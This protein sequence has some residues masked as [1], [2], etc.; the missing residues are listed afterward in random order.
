MKIQQA[1]SAAYEASKCITRATFPWNRGFLKLKLGDNE[2]NYLFD[3]YNANGNKCG[4]GSKPQLSDI[5]ANDWEV[6]D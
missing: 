6:C 2:E 4:H 3:L 1:I 5:I